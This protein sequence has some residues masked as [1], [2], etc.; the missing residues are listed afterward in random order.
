MQQHTAIATTMQQEITVLHTIKV[1]RIATSTPC[2]LSHSAHGP[3]CRVYIAM[4][5]CKTLIVE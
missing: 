5:N 3:K 1:T 4:R 2:S